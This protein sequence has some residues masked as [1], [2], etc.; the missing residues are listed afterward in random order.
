MKLSF[1]H[2]LLRF[3]LRFFLSSFLSRYTLKIPIPSHIIPLNPKSVPGENL[4]AGKS[5][6]SPPT[7]K[8][9]LCGILP[10]LPNPKAG[11]IPTIVLRISELL[12][13]R[14]R[15]PPSLK[16]SQT[17]ILVYNI[18]LISNEIRAL[19][20]ASDFLGEYKK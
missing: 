7:A 19:S 16:G 5:P 17:R 1:R 3:F 6:S 14:I 9:S 4:S 10:L 20:P 18:L 12:C 13:T 15:V 2:S 8:L 11:L